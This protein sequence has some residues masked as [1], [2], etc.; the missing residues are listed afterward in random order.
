[1]WGVGRVEAVASQPQRELGCVIF[2][3]AHPKRK[4]N[5]HGIKSHGEC[6]LAHHATPEGKRGNRSY[7]PESNRNAVAQLKKLSSLI[8]LR[9]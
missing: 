8:E 1:M 7:D 2:Y 4:Q 6:M 5:S 9:G 3:T